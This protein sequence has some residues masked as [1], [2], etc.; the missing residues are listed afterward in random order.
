MDDAG[1]KPKAV[2]LRLRHLVGLAPSHHC[3]E[4]ERGL[5]SFDRRPHHEEHGVPL[6][7][8]W[9]CLPGG[10]WSV[11]MLLKIIRLAA[12]KHQLEVMTSL[13]KGTFIN[14]AWS[15]GVQQTYIQVGYRWEDPENDQGSHERDRQHPCG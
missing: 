5:A 14:L 6:R 1:M 7:R 13:C 11:Q 4:Q 3:E 10:M 8:T 9:N 15:D 2:A 12:A